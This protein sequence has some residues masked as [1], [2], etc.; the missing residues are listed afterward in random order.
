MTTNIDHFNITTVHPSWLPLLQTALQELDPAYLNFLSTN[1]QW[2]PG[3]DKIFSAFSL[4]LTSTRYILF[5]ESPYPRIQS[6]NGYAFWD[7]AVNEIWAANG[8]TKAVNRATSLR[9]FIKMLLVANHDLTLADTSQIAIAKLNKKNYIKQLSEL[10]KNLIDH[11]FL[12]LNA[13]LVLSD[14]AVAK[15]VRAWRPFMNKLLELLTQQNPNIQLIL[16]GRL[17]QLIEQIPAAQDYPKICAEHPY[18]ISFIANRT[19]QQFFRPLNLL[20]LP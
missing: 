19:I 2:L 10:F 11:G 14:Q 18:N 1:H 3:K 9:N 12:L 20:K 17:A 4:A 7:N 16:F 13:S 8:L 6:A 15:N 5:G